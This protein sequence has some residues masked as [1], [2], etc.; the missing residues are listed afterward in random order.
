MELEYE[1]L[2]SKTRKQ[3]SFEVRENAIRLPQEF[4]SKSQVIF[5]EVW[6]SPVLFIE[7]VGILFLRN[8][9]DLVASLQ[10]GRSM[11]RSCTTVIAQGEP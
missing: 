1:I 2:K 10:H 8:R 11:A 7:D 5:W 4:C 3:K 6:L 9:G